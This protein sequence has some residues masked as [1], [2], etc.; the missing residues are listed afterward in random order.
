[1]LH[2]KFI[3]LKKQNKVNFKLK[4]SIPDARL[5]GPFQVLWTLTVSGC[6]RW[7]DRQ[8]LKLGSLICTVRTILKVKAKRKYYSLSL[9]K[10]SFLEKFQRFTIIIK[11]KYS[12]TRIISTDLF[13]FL[14]WLVGLQGPNELLHSN[15]W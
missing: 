9:L 4:S 7:N 2:V 5:S 11:T 1:M 15:L 12:V 8:D 3:Q 6:M 14:L 13:I 10:S